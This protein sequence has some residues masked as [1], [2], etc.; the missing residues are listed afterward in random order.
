MNRFS[1]LILP[2]ILL[3]IYFEG[4]IPARQFDDMKSARMRCDSSLTELKARYETFTAKEKELNI[5]IDDLNKQVKSLTT[6]TMQIGIALRRLT[7]NY[8]KLNSTYDLLLDKNA[9][10]LKGKDDD[11]KKLMG[12]YQ[13]TQEELQKKEDKLR[14][15]LEDLEKRKTEM[16]ILAAELKA[17]EEALAKKEARVAELESVLAKKDSVVKALKDK[18]SNALLGFQGNG[19]NVTQ[20]NGKVYVSL[21]ERLLFESGSI[22]VDARGAE[23]IKNLSKLLEKEPDIN[24]LVEGHTDNVPIKSAAVKDNWDLS[25]L[26]ATSIVRIIIQSSKVNETRLTAAGR[27]EFFPIDKANTAEA[28]KKNRRTEIILTPKLDELFQILEGN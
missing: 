3:S 28:R 10:L 23:A 19:L 18:V 6:D 15:S 20:K 16:D 14:V 25:V 26:R 11:N 5:K 12:Q 22:T 21:E 1:K 17:N 13:L 4:C 7:T 24:I 27:G 9:D 2:V 8:D